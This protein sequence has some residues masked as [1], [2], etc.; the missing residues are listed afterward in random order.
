MSFRIGRLQI[1]KL[2]LNPN[3]KMQI[4]ECCICISQ[5]LYITPKNHKK[6]WIRKLIAEK[7]NNRYGE[8]Q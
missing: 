2:Q 4:S 1:K 7:E 5:Q 3:T 8:M 6:T